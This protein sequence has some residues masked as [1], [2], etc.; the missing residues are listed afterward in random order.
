MAFLRAFGHYLPGRIVPNSEIAKL[1][2]AEPEWIFKAA[3][4][5]ERRFADDSESVESM[6][7][8][9]ARACL[10]NAGVAA[11]EVGLILMASGSAPSKFPGPASAV[12]S[13]L[14]IQGVPAID[15][16]IAS[17]GS[18][19][20][21][22]LAAHLAPAY[23]NVLVIGSE[24]M[25]RVVRFHP[26]TRDTAILFGDGAGAALVG[27][28]TGFARI[29][30]S[31]LASDGDF[32]NVLSLDSSGPLQMDGKTVILQA[33]RKLPRVIGELLIR[34]RVA[35]ADV[36]VFLMHQ[37]NRNL[38]TRVAQSL[39]VSDSRFFTNLQDY[40]NTSSAS[41]LIAAAE[42]RQQKTS[43]PNGPIVFAAFG[44]GLHWG[45]LLAQLSG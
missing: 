14:S 22:A 41:M 39:G 8:A 13:G 45:A 18:L 38:T 36:Q 15:L 19:F 44:A 10:V 3:G 6:G 42:W 35:P 11:R 27:S 2:G 34:C 26:E 28:E 17:A 25:S 43:P 7:I 23:R 12:G 37:A 21:L 20:G 29:V 40:G 30:D 5:R 24:I 9:A 4:I 32:R 33:S 31:S 16:P 1:T